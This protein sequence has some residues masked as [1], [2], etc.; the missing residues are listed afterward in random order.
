MI[1]PVIGLL[2]KLPVTDTMQHQPEPALEIHLRNVEIGNIGQPPVPSLEQGRVQQH[3][4]GNDQ[5]V[6]GGQQVNKRKITLVIHQPKPETLISA[7]RRGFNIYGIRD[8]GQ[9][10]HTPV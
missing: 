6:N 3:G 7:V 1:Q 4:S 9:G 10:L 8:R 5:Q 2:K